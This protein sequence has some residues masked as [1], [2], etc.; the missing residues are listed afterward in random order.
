MPRLTAELLESFSGAFLSPM[1]DSPKP[2]PDFHREIW[3]LYCSDALQAAVAAPRGHAKSTALTHDFCLGMALFRQEPYIMVLGSSEEM[4]V[5]HLGDIS[6]ELHEND[7]LIREFGIGRFITDQKTDLVVEC[8]GG[9][10]FRIVARGAEQKIRGRKW[11]G[12]R[13]GL[14]V[15]DDVED[16]EQVENRDRRNKFYHWITR[17]ALQALRDGGKFRWHGTILHED[18][19]LAKIMRDPQWSTLRYRAHKSFDDFSDIL[20]PELWPESKLRARRQTFINAGDSGGYSQEYLNDPLDNDDQYLR[21]DDFIEMSEEDREADKIFYA[22]ADLAVSKL[23]HANR[24]CFSVAGKCPQNLLHFVDVRKNRW[25]PTEWIDQMFDIQ[26]TWNP[27]LFFVEGGP[28][29][30]A[31]EQ[32]V[33]NE[34]RHRDTWIRL[35]VINPVKDKAVRGRPYQKRMRAHGCRFDKQALWYEEF[36]YENLRFRTESQAQLDDQFD[37]PALLVK[38]LETESPEVI[39]EEFEPEEHQELRRSYS[40]EREGASSTTGY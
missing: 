7:E 5:E 9:Y 30:K 39:A 38:G 11:R 23:D 12:R 14:I 13:P 20:W 16:D 25:D 2:T 24:T 32:M 37:S 15:A 1:Y 28:I 17:A 33:L 35:C 26:R 3:E 10:Q 22:A 8:R 36:E 27:D 19:A 6:T 21:K 18:S 31:V 4:A 40:N 34:M 29:W